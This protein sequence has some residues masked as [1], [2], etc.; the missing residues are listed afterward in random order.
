MEDSTIDERTDPGTDPFAGT[1]P[2]QDSGTLD[3]GG[4][5]TETAGGIV[6][7]DEQ[8]ADGPVTTRFAAAI[9]ARRPTPPRT[10]DTSTGTEPGAST[11]GAG[12]SE[13][14]QA[15]YESARPSLVGDYPDEPAQ[16]PTRRTRRPRATK[17]EP[18]GKTATERLVRSAC[19]GLFLA[20]GATLRPPQYLDAW[21]NFGD[22]DFDPAVAH[23]SAALERVPIEK[24]EQLA[25]YADPILGFVA[26]YGVYRQARGREAELESYYAG[27]VAPEVYGGTTGGNGTGGGPV[28]G[29]TGNNG[30]RGGGTAQ[31]RNTGGNPTGRFRG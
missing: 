3:G 25:L 2:G 12:T 28:P 30:T 5:G 6:G 17:A 10:S 27:L 18:L 19:H 22:K 8:V 21:A 20:I 24:Q 13:G 23:F 4:G 11:G 31:P 16:E 15:S 26:L 29:E 14:R 9:A 1:D 7:R